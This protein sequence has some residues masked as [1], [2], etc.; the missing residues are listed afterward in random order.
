VGDRPC[1]GDYRT[2]RQSGGTPNPGA[3][4]RALAWRAVDDKDGLEIQ[5]G[6]TNNLAHLDAWRAGR[7]GYPVVNTAMRELAAIGF[8]QNRTRMIVAS[9]LTRDL[10]LDWR[11]GER[12][13]MRHL[14][15]GDLA[16]NNGGWQ[17]AAGAGAGTERSPTSAS[18]TRC[19]RASASI[20][21]GSYVW[22]WV[23][24]LERM[25]ARWIHRPWEAPD[26]VLL[27]E[28]GDRLGAGYP[29]RIVEYE[30]QRE[31]ALAMY[32]IQ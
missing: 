11:P 6:L 24:E 13:F 14:V 10:L 19:S 15:D 4:S 25:P 9:F 31:L 12:H 20:S 2:A 32:R 17:W 7:A 30:K 23:H 1:G 22:R 16:S 5:D 27:E 26:R 18:S 29:E 28:A 3:E 21:E 8:L